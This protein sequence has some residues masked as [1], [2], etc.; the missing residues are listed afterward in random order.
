MDNDFDFSQVPFNWPLCYV[1]Q[2][3]RHEECLRYQANLH[4]P[5]QVT[6]HPCVMPTALEYDSCPHFHPIRKVRA[7]AGFRY[8]VSELKEKDL[9]PIRV[10]MTAYLGSRATYYRYKNGQL[11]LTPAQQE[12][13]KK[14]LQRH[15]YT[16]EVR[17]DG[18]QEIYQFL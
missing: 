6:T 9:Y 5:K 13:I 17:F 14:I 2:C 16:N 18:Y 3:P 10:E 15:G 11:L 8:I 4:A 7:A 12:R 1:G